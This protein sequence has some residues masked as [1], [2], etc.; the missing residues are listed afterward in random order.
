MIFTP[1]AVPTELRAPRC[2]A[3]FACM[4]LMI[5]CGSGFAN[6]ATVVAYENGR[7]WTGDAFESGTR[8]VAGGVFVEAPAKAPTF[9]IDLRGA[10]L[11]P[12]FGDARNHRAG[13]PPEVNAPAEAAGVFYLMN[14]NLLASSAAAIRE[15][16]AG[17]SKI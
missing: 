8:Y 3:A 9:T 6:S 1:G 14:P 7:W 5:A 11:V 4:L 15:T 2:M 10:F 12:P 13:T 17:P 16:L